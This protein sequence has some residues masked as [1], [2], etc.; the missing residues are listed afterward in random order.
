MIYS[1]PDG[2]AADSSGKITTDSETPVPD[3]T[4]T[5]PNGETEPVGFE[6]RHR[7]LNRIGKVAIACYF[8]G[9]KTPPDGENK[10]LAIAAGD[11]FSAA[12]RKRLQR[13][14][15][16]SV[17]ELALSLYLQTEYL[18]WEDLE[19]IAI[20]VWEETATNGEKEHD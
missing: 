6:L 13:S 20:D 17:E 18:F 3:D 10:V 12:G 9:G 11:V 2:P 8:T 16:E 7:L 4:T 5:S 1:T 15:V 14:L 19:A